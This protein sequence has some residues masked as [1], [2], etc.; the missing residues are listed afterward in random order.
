MF[1]QSVLAAAILA[2]AT[3]A[4]AANPGSVQPSPWNFG[5]AA[6]LLTGT[7]QTEGQ[8]RPCGSQAAYQPVVNTMT[9]HFGGTVL[10]N[11]RFP[12]AGVQNAF[13][14]PGLFTRSAGLGA[15]TY[16]PGKR[17]YTMTLRYDYFVDGAFYGIGVVDRDLTLSGDGRTVSGPVQV[18]M[19]NTE[20]AVLRK[21]CGTATSTRI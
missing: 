13:G 20:G 4:G 5:W 16:N 10:E 6:N 1:K 2:I 9:F 19:Y 17:T 14:I 7:Y 21:L 12:P 11:P 15:W 18:T 3:T 8:V